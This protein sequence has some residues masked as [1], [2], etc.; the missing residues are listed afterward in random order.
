MEFVK[1]TRYI[2]GSYF[3]SNATIRQVLC[4]G[5]KL[6]LASTDLKKKSKNPPVLKLFGFERKRDLTKKP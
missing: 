1:I 4:S 6:L 3:D 5:F 2:P